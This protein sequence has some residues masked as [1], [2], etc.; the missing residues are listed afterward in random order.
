MG[1]N[2]SVAGVLQII[3]LLGREALMPGFE[4]D[5]TF[6]IPC[7]L[8]ALMQAFPSPN[9]T[10]GLEFTVFILAFQGPVTLRSLSNVSP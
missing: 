10:S 7:K 9:K 1:N 2:W 4:P 5:R 8:L 6:A 3:S